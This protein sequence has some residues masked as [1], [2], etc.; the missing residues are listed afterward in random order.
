MLGILVIDNHKY[1]CPDLEANIGEEC[2]DSNG[3][4]GVVSS[5]CECN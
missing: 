3:N 4:M 2:R 1:D 5:A